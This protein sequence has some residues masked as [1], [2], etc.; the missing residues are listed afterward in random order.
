[1]LSRNTARFSIMVAGTKGCGKSSFFNNIVGKNIVKEES[2]DEIN[3]YMLNLDCEGVM[4]RITFIDTPGFNTENDQKI[5]KSILNYIKEQFDAFMT[6]ENKIRRNPKYEDTRVHCLLYFF[7]STGNGMKQTDL[8]FLQQVK[9]LVNIIP[10]I[11]KADGLVSSEVAALKDLIREQFK[12]NEIPIFD[13]ENVAIAPQSILDLKLNSMVPFTIING[14]DKLKKI[15]HLTIEIDNPHFN[16]LSSLREVILSSHLESFINLT[17]EDL[18]E[19]YR[20]T[21]LEKAMRENID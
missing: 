3:I 7:P 17:S 2:N 10:V 12:E 8:H 6:E 20:T 21:I 15:N 9:S 5:Q 11:S 16:D 4:Q 13:L 18:Y 14:E 19:S 1:M